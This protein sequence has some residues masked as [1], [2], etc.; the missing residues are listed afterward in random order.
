[1]A[2]YIEHIR[3]LA[4]RIHQSDTLPLHWHEDNSDEGLYYFLAQKMET[5]GLLN[6]ERNGTC[7]AVQGLTARGRKLIGASSTPSA[8]FLND[9]HKALYQ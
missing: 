1:M 7:I 6:A 2:A 8:E 3:A 5:A 4:Q 9:I